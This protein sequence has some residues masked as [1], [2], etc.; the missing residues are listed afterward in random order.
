MNLEQNDCT[1][2]AKRKFSDIVQL[3]L[4]LQL[5]CNLKDLG[6]VKIKIKIIIIISHRTSKLPNSTFT[7]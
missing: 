1:P 7:F 5:E 2:F 4:Y 6:K 3:R